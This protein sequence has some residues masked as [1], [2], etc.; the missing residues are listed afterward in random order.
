DLRGFS[1]EHAGPSA[2]DLMGRVM[3]VS[4]A[5]YP[6]LMD[7]CFLVN[8]PWIFFAVFKGVKPLMSAHTVAKVKLVKLKRV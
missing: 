3:S 4:C 2:R 8:A 6:E 7:T 5:N 1:M